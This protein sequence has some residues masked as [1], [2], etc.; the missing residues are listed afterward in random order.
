MT[1]PSGPSEARTAREQQ[2][3]TNRVVSSNGRQIVPWPWDSAVA[4]AG[5]SAVAPI[6]SVPADAAAIPATF[7]ALARSGALDLPQPGQGNTL[8]RF[9]ALAEIS[10]LDLSLGRLAEGHSDALAIL[11]EAGRPAP[12]GAVLGVWAARRPDS[13]VSV[14]PT[15]PRP[16]A[17]KTTSQWHLSGRKP[18]ASG[19]RTLTHALITAASD[20]GPRLFLV[21]LTGAAHVVPDTWPAVGM[22][23]SQSF[24]VDIDIT[25]GDDCRLGG[26]GW[27]VERT[28]FWF[29]SVGVAACWFG[30]ALGLARSLRAHLA[31]AATDIDDHQAA[32]L[33][34]AAARVSS[35]T[36]DLAWA[37]HRLDSLGTDLAVDVAV[38]HAHAHEAQAIAFEVRHLV[39][40]GCLEVLNRVSRAG[41]AG[42]LC[43]DAAQAR[44]LADLPVYIRQHHAGRDEATLGRRFLARPAPGTSP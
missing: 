17:S 16:A 41:G 13:D 36:R 44:R 9:F 31:R 30:G 12:P 20:A 42:P 35:M 24:D 26:P 15:A 43:Q 39:E 33:G 32:Q 38:D 2:I 22:A 19:A 7:S 23:M 18:W 40:T 37:A 29:G 25:I 28:G 10:A 3:G 27:Y 21:P 34:A 4:P 14:T 6:L 11:A 5:V 8:A 1:R